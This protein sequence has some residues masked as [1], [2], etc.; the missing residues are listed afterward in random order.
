ML[1]NSTHIHEL[2]SSAELRSLTVSQ[3]TLFISV[4]QSPGLVQGPGLYYILFGWI[5]IQ[6]A[7]IL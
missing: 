3:L 1:K 4:V 2:V 7:R 6:A 5:I